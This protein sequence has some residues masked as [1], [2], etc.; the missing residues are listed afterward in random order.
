M[1]LVELADRLCRGWANPANLEVGKK[2]NCVDYG[3][4]R[5]SRR[6]FGHAKYP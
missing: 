3:K 4:R 1:E 6:A 2:A 5:K